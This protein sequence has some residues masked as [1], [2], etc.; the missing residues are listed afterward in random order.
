VTSVEQASTSTVTVSAVSSLATEI[1]VTTIALSVCTGLSSVTAPPVQSAGFQPTAFT[2]FQTSVSSPAVFVVTSSASAITSPATSS[3]PVSISSVTSAVG[4]EFKPI[5]PPSTLAPVSA[6]VGRL[7]STRGGFVF[8]PSKPAATSLAAH[9]SVSGSTLF[10]QSTA[11]FKPVS[12]IAVSTPANCGIAATQTTVPASTTVTSFSLPGANMSLSTAVTAAAHSVSSSAVNFLTNCVPTTASSYLSWPS[13]PAFGVSTLPVTS[14]FP[15]ASLLSSQLAATTSASTFATAVPDHNSLLVQPS[16][17]ADNLFQSVTDTSSSVFGGTYPTVRPDLINAATT[18]VSQRMF[19]FSD[20]QSQEASS[21]T[22]FPSV[23][24]SASAFGLSTT[25]ANMAS[26]NPVFVFSN[27]S[28]V[29]AA[30]DLFTAVTSSAPDSQNS[31]VN[32]F[33]NMNRNNQN[34]SFGLQSQAVPSA[35][36]FGEGCILRLFC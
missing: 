6:S 2:V 30:P 10:L 26:V 25:S 3:L 34:V 14:A 23:N 21:S 12:G 32:P 7:P 9:T 35:F 11:G 16:T 33:G 5:F 31:R 24:H 29:A 4:S 22:L 27:Q 13:L 36:N 17:N 20:S 1:P 15:A 19:V 28:T 8:V 18:T